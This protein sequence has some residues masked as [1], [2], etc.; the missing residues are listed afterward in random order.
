MPVT[1]M[2][3]KPK[4]RSFTYI[5]RVLNTNYEPFDA[6]LPVTVDSMVRKEI[7]LVRTSGNR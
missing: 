6:V 3:Y 7:T 2:L 5:D 4:H 1:N